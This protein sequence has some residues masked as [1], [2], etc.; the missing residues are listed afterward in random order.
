MSDANERSRLPYGPPIAEAAASGDLQRMKAVAEAARSALFKVQFS[1][2]D[3]QN[4]AD[5]KSALAELEAAI[6]RL[7]GAGVRSV[8]GGPVP[9]YGVPIRDA[10]AR[11]NLQEMKATAAAAR[12]ALFGV[13][14][15]SAGQ[16]NV[17]ESRQALE[18]LEAAIR[19]L[20]GK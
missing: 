19:K 13:Q 9:P 11:G 6:G 2:V 7:E 16:S 3:K 4:E 5:V 1:P 10:I 12:Q 15:Q 17:E 20:E 14:F 18:K 8:G